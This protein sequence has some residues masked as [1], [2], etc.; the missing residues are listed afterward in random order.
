MR[1]L[2]VELNPVA[3]QLPGSIRITSALLCAL[4]LSQCKAINCE[5]TQV[6]GVSTL[7]LV[8]LGNADLRVLIITVENLLKMQNFAFKST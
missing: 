1:R 5:A 7:R 3:Y 6:C 4:N 8:V 2:Q